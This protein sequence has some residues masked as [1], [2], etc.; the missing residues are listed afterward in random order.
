MDDERERLEIDSRVRAALRTNDDAWRRVVA[1][2]LADA[3]RS[4]PHR[5]RGRLAIVTA[6]ALVLILG[7][8]AA[9]QWRRSAAARSLSQSLTV[10][11]AGSML[12]IESQDGRRWIIGPSTPRRS[13]NYVMVV[14]E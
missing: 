4:T 11:R 2:A 10:T 6:A 14:T 8:V 5:W 1:R 12:I 3:P 7:V 13:G 9:V